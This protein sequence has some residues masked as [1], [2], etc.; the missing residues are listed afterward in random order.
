MTDP[1]RT[2]HTSEP[3]KGA[4]DPGAQPDG[5]TPHP[6]QPAEGTDDTPGGADT[7]GA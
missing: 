4:D 2:A 6:D 5:Q 3:A 7:P 1:D